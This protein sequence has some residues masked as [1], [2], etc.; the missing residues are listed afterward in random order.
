MLMDASPACTKSRALTKKVFLI[1]AINRQHPWGNKLEKGR[2]CRRRQTKRRGRDGRSPLRH[3]MHR[4]YRFPS[5]PVIPRAWSLPQDTNMEQG[6]EKSG[7][8]PSLASSMTSGAGR[9]PLT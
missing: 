4:G 6:L 9:L 1:L 2:H 3:A 7:M 5:S 8:C